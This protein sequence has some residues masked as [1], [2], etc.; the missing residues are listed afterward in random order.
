MCG[1]HVV[2]IGITSS[3]INHAFKLHI[4]VFHEESKSFTSLSAS[5]KFI[6]AM[7]LVVKKTR[8]SEV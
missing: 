4:Y 1:A 2:P 5:P 6:R 8:L 3:L 7:L